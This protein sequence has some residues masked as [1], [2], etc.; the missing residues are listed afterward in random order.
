MNLSLCS[1]IF[2]QFLSLS[3]VAV[4]SLRA[5]SYILGWIEVVAIA[6]HE[7]HQGS[8]IHKII[9]FKKRKKR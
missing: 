8:Q 7:S 9:L 4:L 1:L 6:E 5:S 2:H 3:A